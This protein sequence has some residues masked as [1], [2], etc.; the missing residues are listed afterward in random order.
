MNLADRIRCRTVITVG[1]WDDICPP[2]SVFAAYNHIEAEKQIEVF[3]FM[4]H[5]SPEHFA[6]T[7]FRLMRT[8]L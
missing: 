7:R 5:E 8:G 6:E 1:L 2:S 3:D 4:G